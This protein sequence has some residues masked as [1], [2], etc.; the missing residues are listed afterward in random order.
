MNICRKE[1]VVACSCIS[2]LV[3]TGQERDI[4]SLRILHFFTS[5]YM[6]LIFFIVL[7]GH[8]RRQTRRK[9]QTHTQN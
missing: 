6:S 7:L 3:C 1:G 2:D 4:E 8:D 5:K 9:G